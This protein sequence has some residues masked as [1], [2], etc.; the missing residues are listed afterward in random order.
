M[1]SRPPRY[2]NQTVELSDIEYGDETYRLTTESNIDDLMLS[3]GNVGL[4]NPPLLL[5]NNSKYTIVCGFGRVEASQRLGR[6]QVEARILAPGLK[7]LDCARL[8]IT[9][10]ALQRPLNLIETSRSIVLL[11]GLIKDDGMLTD[12]LSALGL[13]KEPSIIKK[14]EKLCH[15]SKPIQRAILSH[16]ISLSM[17]LELGALAPDVGTRFVELFENLKLSLNK[18]R[19]VLSMVREIALREECSVGEVLQE[20]GFQDILNHGDLDRNQKTRTARLH[21]KQ[22]RYPALTAAEKAFGE[23]IKDLKLKSGIKL[24]PPHNFEGSNYT[25]TLNFKNLTELKDFRTTFDA[26]IQNPNLEKL[27]D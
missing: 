22:R 13:P 20:K 5:E 11:S 17:A 26:I 23:L 7:E 12:E 18:Q 14:I 1:K 19:E 24:I 6:D 25:L 21:L 4:L 10:N 9:D 3:I 16:T 15:F 27:M 8:A 2:K